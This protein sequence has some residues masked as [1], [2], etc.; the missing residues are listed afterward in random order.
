MKKLIA[1]FLAVFYSSFLFATTPSPVSVLNTAGSTA[2][3]AI[4]S[5]GPAGP[6]GWGNVSATA[7]TGI[8]PVVHG[9]TNASTASGTALDNIT[10]F[11]GTGF[12]T[13][14]GAGAYAFQS[15]TN[16]IT[17]ANLNQAAANSIVGNSTGATASLFTLAVPS[18]STSASALIWASGAGFSC[19]TSVLASN[20][21][22]TVAV[23]NGGTGGGTAATARSNLGAAASG[24]NTDITSL[25]APALGAATA[26]TAAP[27]TNTTQVCTTAFATA[28]VAAVA[29]TVMTGYTPTV[30]A[31]SGAF[32]TVSA[33]GHYYVIGKLVFFELAVTITTVGTASGNVFATLPFGTNTSGGTLAFTGLESLSTGKTL[34]GSAAANSGSVTI[35]FYDL[36]SAIAAGNVL[37]ISGSYVSN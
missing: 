28:A 34:Q 16:G 11:S 25:N 30:T 1:V 6:A 19:N 4:V 5:P 15:A 10:G 31:G 14:T 7:L 29:P 26:T 37:V 33:T 32:T 12:L 36:T 3:Q 21:S 27:G 23:A 24:A 9:G 2:G 22:G 13:R 8:T 35:R 17:L 18:C 20:V